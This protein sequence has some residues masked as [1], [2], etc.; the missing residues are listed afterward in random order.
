MAISRV[1]SVI[2]CFPF[3]DFLCKVTVMYGDMQS[4][5]TLLKTLLIFRFNI[6]NTFYVVNVVNFI[7]KTGCFTVKVLIKCNMGK[8]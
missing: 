1:V 6:F 3:D 4:I 8:G 5:E 7:L 2:Q